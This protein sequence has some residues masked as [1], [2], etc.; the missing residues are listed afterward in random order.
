MTNH[1]V[2]HTLCTKPDTI[3]DAIKQNTTRNVEE[4]YAQMKVDKTP[5]FDIMILTFRHQF[6]LEVLS[7]CHVFKIP[8][9]LVI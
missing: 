3:T 6:S 7:K 1:V 4:E 5:I 8:N 2:T 9:S